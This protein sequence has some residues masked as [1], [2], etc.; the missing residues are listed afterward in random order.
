MS[1]M[2][3]HGLAE[4]VMGRQ[5]AEV[6]GPVGIASMS[7]RAMASG[8]WEFITF[9]AIIAL[10][11]GILNLFPI[12]ALDGGRIL[13]VLLEMIFRRRLP[14]K[15]EDWIHTAGFVV[16]ISLMILVTFKDVYTLFFT[17]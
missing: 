7:G 17:R 13:F 6:T 11:L 8:F 15:V 5:E 2:M 1:V 10:N 9:I 3:L 14:E 4:F 16:L 12:P